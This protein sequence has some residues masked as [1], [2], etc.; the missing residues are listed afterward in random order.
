LEIV[1]PRLI[2]RRPAKRDA[3]S[4]AAL[5]SP[6][7]SRWLASWPEVLAVGAARLRIAEALRQIDQAEA[8]H[9]VV[10]R[11]D[12]PGPIGWI[13]ITRSETRLT[14]GELGFWLGAASQGHGFATEAVRAAIPAAFERLVLTTIEGGAQLGNDASQRVMYKIGMSPV[15]RRAVWSSARQRFEQCIVYE[16]SADDVEHR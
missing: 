11:R 13:R 16:L 7:V 12:I 2:L 15:G 3:E 9:W 5:M 14:T 6:D 1:T 4:I 10:E 8:L